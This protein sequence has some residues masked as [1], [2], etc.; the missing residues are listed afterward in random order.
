MLPHSS[1]TRTPPPPSSKRC[2]T[3]EEM[4]SLASGLSATIVVSERQQYELVSESFDNGHGDKLREKIRSSRRSSEA[5]A[6]SLLETGPGGDEDLATG[7]GG[8]TVFKMT[9]TRSTARHLDILATHPNNTVDLPAV[10]PHGT[11]TSAAP[12]AAPGAAPSAANKRLST[13]N[14]RRI[15]DLVERKQRSVKHERLKKGKARA[16]SLGWWAWL[17]RH[18]RRRRRVGITV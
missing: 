5:T 12:G 14:D 15:S 11:I 16:A 4:I 2:P 8:V 1:Y 13:S 6:R 7:V 17:K 3:A 9:P 10:L 18:V